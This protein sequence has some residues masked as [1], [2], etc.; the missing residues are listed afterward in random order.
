VDR[1]WAFG[2]VVL[3]VALGCRPK[4][5]LPS[6]ADAAV[7][8]AAT[9]PSVAPGSVHVEEV[10]VPGDLPVA[11]VRGA[12]AHRMAMV[13]VPGMCVHPTGY[14]MS[15]AHAAAL[16][17][18]LI[19]VQGDV[20]CAEGSPFRR[21]S[22]DLVAMDR[23]IEAGLRAAGIDQPHE[24]VLIGYSQGAE[25]AEKLVALFPTKYTSVVLIASPVAPSARLLGHARAVALLAGT[26]DG[27]HST[28]RGAVPFLTQAGIRSA[29]FSIPGAR[30]G[31]LGEHPN[32]AMAEVLD[33]L[34]R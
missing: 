12:S 10:D 1:R 2:A 30:H 11:A 3:A 19:G 23:R 17:G 6:I 32:E 34:E 14:V 18:D 21:W 22:N 28:M 15:F 24:I 20:A 29:F 27:A 25:R 9:T 8:E 26:F 33:F 16:H 5:S 31:Q 7:A 4:T 13:F